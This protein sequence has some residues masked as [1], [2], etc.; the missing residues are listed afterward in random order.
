MDI[1]IENK[2]WEELQVPDSTGVCEITASNETTKPSEIDLSPA[3]FEIAEIFLREKLSSVNKR[4]TTKLAANTIAARCIKKL[5]QG[6]PITAR[7]N[8]DILATEEFIYK[9]DKIEG[10]FYIMIDIEKKKAFDASLVQQKIRQ[11]SS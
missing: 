10:Q 9:I 6:S 8:L 5:G 3:M 7:R 1:T 11:E 4:L 2:K